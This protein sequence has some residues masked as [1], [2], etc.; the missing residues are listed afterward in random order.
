M[1]RRDRSGR[2]VRSGRVTKRRVVMSLWLFAHFFLRKKKCAK[3]KVRRSMSEQP[4]SVDTMVRPLIGT[5]AG[6]DGKGAYICARA[7]VRTHVGHTPS[8]PLPPSPLFRPPIFP[9]F[10]PPSLLYRGSDPLI[11]RENLEPISALGSVTTATRPTTPT[12][13]SLF[14][15]KKMCQSE[16]LLEGRM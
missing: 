10:R 2:V 14:A 4:D 7:P 3:T 8:S 15:A 16:H 1:P 12:S 13:R 9:L 6:G 5:S 11:F